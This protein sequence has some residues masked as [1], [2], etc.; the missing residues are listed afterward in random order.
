MARRII[1]WLRGAAVVFAAAAAAGCPAPTPGPEMLDR[2]DALCR[3]GQWLP[4]T[5]TLK[6]YLMHHPEDAGAHFLLG[7]CYLYLQHLVLAEGEF[8]T[9]RHYFTAGGRENPLPRFESADYFEMMTYI[10]ISKVYLQQ[11]QLMMQLNASPDA[12]SDRLDRWQQALDAARKIKPDS[13]D[14]AAGQ[15]LHD[16]LER[17]IAAFPAMRDQP[18]RAG[19]QV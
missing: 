12:L 13:P 18:A 4:A 10:E 9:A 17:E 5:E 2:A 1:R 7:R 19:G 11:I 3:E 8:E 14:V 6:Y 16:L 15:E